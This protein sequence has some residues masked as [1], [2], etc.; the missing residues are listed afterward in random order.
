MRPHQAQ[1]GILKPRFGKDNI[2]DSF[3]GQ[4]FSPLPQ[5]TF[6][7]CCSLQLHYSSKSLPAT[8]VP[9][10]SPSEPSTPPPSTADTSFQVRGS[11]ERGRSHGRGGEGFRSRG[12]GDCRRHRGSWHRR[13][14]SR[15]LR[16]RAQVTKMNTNTHTHTHTSARAYTRVLLPSSNAASLP[17]SRVTIKL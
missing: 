6:R 15:P 2:F 3:S 12:S 5:V 8:A 17:F 10:T 4:F 14:P 13:C 1:P 7:Q 9:V 16:L 11:G